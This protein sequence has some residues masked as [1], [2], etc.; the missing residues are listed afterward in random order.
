MARFDTS[1]A[2]MA[3]H[4][5][6]VDDWRCVAGVHYGSE[7]GASEDYERVVL[8]TDTGWIA[9][10]EIARAASGIVRIGDLGHL[11]SLSRPGARRGWATM[12]VT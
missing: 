11:T 2:G 7:P 4:A 12:G 1:R 3:T 5:T 6:R 9:V 10:E 8:A